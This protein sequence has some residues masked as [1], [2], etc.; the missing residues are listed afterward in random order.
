MWWALTLKSIY[1]GVEHSFEKNFSKLGANLWCKLHILGLPSSW[2]SAEYSI[3]AECLDEVIYTRDVLKNFWKMSEV[4]KSGKPLE[5]G[6]NG[7][8]V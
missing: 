4:S 6:E 8:S 5:N 7:G 2:A 3:G 1:V